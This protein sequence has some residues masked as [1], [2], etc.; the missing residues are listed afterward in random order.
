MYE[1][2]AKKIGSFLDR[3]G[4]K[5]V[6]REDMRTY[7]VPFVLKTSKGE[8]EANVLVQ[9]G[10]EWILTVALLMNA[11]MLSNELRG[12]IYEKLL[13][14]TFY[15]NE[16]AYGLTKGKDIVVHAESSFENLSFSNFETKFYSVVY[17]VEYFVNNILPSIDEYR[18]ALYIRKSEKK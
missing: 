4:L 5:Y 13:T 15:L 8:I 3:M 10:D 16:V 9:I 12:E 1:E 18:E 17:G 6:Y 2:V 11:E 14:D 7:L